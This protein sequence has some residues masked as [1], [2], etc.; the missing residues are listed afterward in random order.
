MS[1]IQ[2]DSKSAEQ[3]SE[4]LNLKY[5]FWDR[6]HDLEVKYLNKAH[7]LL[8]YFFFPYCISCLMYSKF[9]FK[10][11]TVLKPRTVVNI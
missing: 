6:I 4:S 5:G 11:N 3:P 2:T 1:E 7:Q 10:T 9:M 8:G